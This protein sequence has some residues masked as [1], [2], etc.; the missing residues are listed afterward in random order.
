MVG[1][2][3][4]SQNS[5]APDINLKIRDL[6]EKQRMLQNQFLLIG[7]NL[8]EI[9]DKSSK[10]IIEIRKDIEIMKRSV[11]RLTSFLDTASEEFPKFARKEDVDIISKQMRMFQPFGGKI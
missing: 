1:D 10:D 2:M 8:I 4:N 3:I 9:K 7:K 5:Y 11:E 6:E